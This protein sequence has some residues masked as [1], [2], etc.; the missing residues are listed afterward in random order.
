MRALTK[1]TF[2]KLQ[3]RA[4]GMEF[5]SEMIIK[6][7]LLG[8]DTVEVT[9]SL[10]PDKRD[11]A[12]HLRPLRDGW[13]HLK[14]MLL[15]APTWVFLVPGSISFFAGSA[16]LATLLFFDPKTFGMFTMFF[17]QGLT[18]LGAHAVFLG[19]TARQFSQIK[20]LHVRSDPIDRFL[21]S[22]TLEKGAALGII[23]V[24]AGVC[25]CCWVGWELLEFISNPANLGIFNMRLTKFGTVFTTFI[26]LGFQLIFSSFYSGLFNVEVSE[27]SE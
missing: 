27:E 13:R 24:L 9:T 2:D 25:G 3:L 22:F 21:K 23:L 26:I 12:P 16:L 18:L 5:A 8:I 14:F 19:I 17:A 10:F 11:R 15:F 20:R 7:S 4:G 1:K 6:A